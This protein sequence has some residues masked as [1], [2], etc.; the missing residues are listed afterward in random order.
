MLYQLPA[1]LLT[2]IIITSSLSQSPIEQLK[3]DINQEIYPNIDGIVVMK[4]KKIIIEEYFNDFDR[5]RLHDTRSSFKSI[6]SILAGIAIDQGLFTVDDSLD[7]FFSKWENDPRGKIKIKDLLEMKS[8]LAC[9]NF[10]GI[11]P[12]CESEM[13][14][15][16]DWIG[17]ILDIPIRHDPGLNWDYTSV[18][19]MLVGEIISRTS[20]MSIM[21]FAAQYLFDPLEIEDY[22]WTISPKGKGM[23]AGSF[24]MRPID[25]LKIAQ[26]VQYEGLWDNQ[27]IVSQK[28]M[29]KSTDCRTDVEMS[30]VRFSRLKNA[31]YSTARYGYYWYQE[32][33]Q[34]EN[35]NTKVTFASGNG[36]QY[37]MILDDFNAVIVFTGSNYGNWRGKLPFV[38]LMKY[39]IP[40]IEN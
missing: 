8:G 29:K 33:L 5:D 3:Q 37:M 39:L 28:W 26:L 38:I 9:E 25:M 36:G 18:E 17:F 12:D 24:Y 40:I 22:K 30:F 4:N 21:D 7:K 11:G 1:I 19:P 2:L 20:K 10:F 34:Y 32:V 14:E 16:D 27:R 31:K 13:W 15:T 6:T 23:S 35:I